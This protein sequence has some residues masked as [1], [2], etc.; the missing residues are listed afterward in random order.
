MGRL[1]VGLVYANIPFE[2]AIRIC[3]N[4]LFGKTERAEGLLKTENKELLSLAT[5]ESYITFNRKL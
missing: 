3:T 2:E 1:N 5:K 4:T